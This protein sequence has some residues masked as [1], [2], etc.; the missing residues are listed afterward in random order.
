MSVTTLVIVLSHHS[1]PSKHR[2]FTC[3]IS[4]NSHP[5]GQGWSFPFYRWGPCSFERINGSSPLDTRASFLYSPDLRVNVTFVPM[6]MKA[7]VLI[8]NQQAA[9]PAV[10]STEVPRHS[11]GKYFPTVATSSLLFAFG[12]GNGPW[13]VVRATELKAHEV[14]LKVIGILENY[15]KHHAG[16][17]YGKCLW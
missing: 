17:A 13:W 14:G 11:V 5:S 3:V 4:V 16:H 6:F 12:R 9:A 7:P 1:V 8:S 2:Q 10:G 15:D